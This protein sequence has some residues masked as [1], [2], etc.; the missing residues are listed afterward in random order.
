MP[1]FF[2]EKGKYLFLCFP[3]ILLQQVFFC[4]GL[5]WVALEACIS[6]GQV[7]SAEQSKADQCIVTSFKQCRISVENPARNPIQRK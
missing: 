6:E 2:H 1:F 3:E 5:E 7:G 4:V